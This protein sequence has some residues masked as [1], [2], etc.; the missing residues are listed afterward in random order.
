MKDSN[1]SF[2]S[3]NENSIQFYK[4]IIQ[5]IW[6]KERNECANYIKRQNKKNENVTSPLCKFN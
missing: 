1:N 6:G 5:C 3:P 4:N 2:N